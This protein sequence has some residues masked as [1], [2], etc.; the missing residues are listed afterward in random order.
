MLENC[1]SKQHRV[2]FIIAVLIH[3]PFIEAVTQ[4]IGIYESPVIL[5]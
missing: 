2:S 4:E 5:K 1:I 3:K